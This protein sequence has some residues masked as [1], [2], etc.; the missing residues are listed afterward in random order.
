[1][2]WC[3]VCRQKWMHTHRIGFILEHDVPLGK[4]LHIP[5][6]SGRFHN[7][8]CRQASAAL[9]FFLRDYST[10]VLMENHSYVTLLPR[11]VRVRDGSLQTFSWRWFYSTSVSDGLIPVLKCGHLLVRNPDLVF[12]VLY[13]KRSDMAHP[14]SSVRITKVVIIFTTSDEW[15]S[16][17]LEDDWWGLSRQE[18]LLL[19]GHVKC[20][21]TMLK[22]QNPS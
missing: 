11:L 4:H 20:G 17:V 18:K 16:H 1:M 14:L 22:M 21:F 12:A 10:F 6:S 19:T 5:N 15:Y 2:F 8:T 3:Y 13:H 9:N 7:A